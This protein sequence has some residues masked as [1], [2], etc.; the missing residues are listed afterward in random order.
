M[1]TCTVCTKRQDISIILTTL[2][3]YVYH[4]LG[5]GKKLHMY[6]LYPHNYKLST[7][8][9]FFIWLYFEQI[10]ILHFSLKGQGHWYLRDHQNLFIR[11]EARVCQWENGVSMCVCE[12]Y[13]QLTCWHMFLITRDLFN[14]TVCFHQ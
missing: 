2:N 1:F 6:W 9:E 4:S 7:P 11:F 8:Y 14:L 12:F 5:V 13:Q 3:A 10:F